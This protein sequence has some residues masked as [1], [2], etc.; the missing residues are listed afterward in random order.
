IDRPMAQTAAAFGKRVLIAA[1]LTST[2]QPTEKL[3]R[4]EGTG[5]HGES[6]HTETLLLPEAW[7]LWQAGD[8]SGYWRTI[9]DRLRPA[10]AGFD[11]IVLAQASMSGAADLLKDT[12]IHVSSS[13]RLG[14]EGAI[15]V[16]RLRNS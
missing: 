1:C 15:K 8:K 4:G 6:F 13:P 2:V 12:G 9:A 16:Y 5:R 11:A 3:V 14:V 7:P 10:A